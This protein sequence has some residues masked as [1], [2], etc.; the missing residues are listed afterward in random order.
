L[1][2]FDDKLYFLAYKPV[3]GY[4]LYCYDENAISHDF[5]GVPSSFFIFNTLTVLNNALYFIAPGQSGEWEIWRFDGTSAAMVTEFTPGLYGSTS[6]ELVDKRPV[7]FNGSIYFTL[8]DW[9][10]YYSQLWRFDGAT[11]S[12]VHTWDGFGTGSIA[13]NGNLYFGGVGPGSTAGEELWRFDGTTLSL[14]ADIYPGANSSSPSNFAVNNNA[15]YFNAYGPKGSELWRYDG[16]TASLVADIYPGTYGSAPQELTELNNALYFRATAPNRQGSTI[17]TELWSYRPERPWR[18]TVNNQALTGIDFGNFRALNMTAQVGG[19]A[20]SGPIDEG[21]EVLFDAGFVEPYSGTSGNV[22]YLWEVSDG[23]GIVQ[24]GTAST[25]AFTPADEGNRWVTITVTDHGDGNRTYTDTM[26]IIA[27]NVAPIV[28]VENRGLYEGETESRWADFFD[29]GIYDTHTAIIDW[30]DGSTSE[31]IVY[32][33]GGY[34]SIEAEHFYI[35]EGIYTVTVTVDD[36]DGGLTTETFTVEVYNAAPSV[37]AD[38][39]TMDE[40]GTLIVAAPGVLAN[41]TDAPGDPLIAELYSEPEFGRLL[42][43]PDGSFSYSPGENFFGEDSFA[44]MAMDDEGA[45]SVTSVT[46]TVIPVN[47]APVA[48][49]DGYR[50]DE[51]SVLSIP[52]QGGLM[53]INGLDPEGI[54]GIGTTLYADFGTEGFFQYDGIA[55]TSVSN[56]NAQGMTAVGSTLYIDFGDS[57]I[58]RYLSGILTRIDTRNPEQLC[59]TSSSLYADFGAGVGLYRYNGTTWFLVSTMDAEGMAAVV[60][61]LCVDFGAS[62]LYRYSGGVLSNV[63]VLN[64]DILYAMKNI[65]YAD[66]GAGVGL[67]RYI[68]MKDGTMRGNLIS[69]LDAEGMTAAGADLFVDFGADGV[70]R[71]SGGVFSQVDTRNPEALQG[72][73]SGLFADFG[74]QEGFCRY[75]G[76]VWTKISSIDVEGM[77][78]VGSDIYVDLGSS[79]THRLVKG[80]LANDTDVEGDVLSA[81]LGTGPSHGNLDLLTDGSLTYTPSANFSGTDSFT[82]RAS[83][84]LLQT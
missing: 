84:G 18:V 64:P 9:D 38:E 55:W 6:L 14:A 20:L 63:N 44:Y 39:Y 7:V 43:N 40:D 81:L 11:A 15:L 12:L 69:T 32:N 24:T 79:G 13:Y 83:D 74:A 48:Q 37:N 62:G 54:Y 76:T 65:L 70:H 22:S 77:A 58:Y 52:A 61:D 75:D 26:E 30:G 25:F 56:M 80:V 78:A 16:T 72:T 73:G 17:G 50:M 36:H 1:T 57:G 53:K 82:Y 33:S 27:E 34:G 71:Y 3:D 59:G 29:P 8:N 46:I 49:E 51:D 35:G 28:E 10:Y 66:F 19:A 5:N 45:Y 31:G 2:V 47:D 60:S 68:G 21:T 42:L 67:Y 41:D 4:D 23:E